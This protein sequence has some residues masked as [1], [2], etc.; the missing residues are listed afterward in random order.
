M[1]TADLM[2]RRALRCAK[3][4]AE[5]SLNA[6][7][8]AAM[9]PAREPEAPPLCVIDTD[10]YVLRRSACTTTN[11]GPDTRYEGRGLY[12]AILCAILLLCN[13]S[14]WLLP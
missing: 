9:S 8:R 10:S 13:G 7:R 3:T 11:L 12:V 2:Q 6:E 14:K 5:A 1:P 4:E